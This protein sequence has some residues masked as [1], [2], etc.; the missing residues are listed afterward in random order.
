MLK[1]KVSGGEV[2]GSIG[3]GL[4]NAT[5]GREV[6]LA[7]ARCSLHSSVIKTNLEEIRISGK[8]SFTCLSNSFLPRCLSCKFIIYMSFRERLKQMGC[9]DPVFK[10][11]ANWIEEISVWTRVHMYAHVCACVWRSEVGVSVLLNCSPP[12]FWR[13]AL[14][15]NI[16]LTDWARQ[17]GQAAPGFFLYLP[18]Q[19]LDYKHVMSCHLCM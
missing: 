16:E 1:A 2:G 6:T 11:L 13:Q 12:Y 9:Q 15:L 14:S 10:Q 18:P 19:K 7:Q 17:V 8:S 3:G 4:R 5:N